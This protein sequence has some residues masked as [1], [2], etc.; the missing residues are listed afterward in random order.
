TASRNPIGPNQRW[1]TSSTISWGI[2]SLVSTW[3]KMAAAARIMKI[4]ADVRDASSAARHTSRSPS[5]R[6]AIIATSIAARAPAPAASV[7]V[8]T[9]KYMPPRTNAGRDRR[10]EEHTSEL[11]SRENLV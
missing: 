6:Y 10:S 2:R 4:I 11:Q 8:K 9:P 3:L 5:E 7:A 1:V